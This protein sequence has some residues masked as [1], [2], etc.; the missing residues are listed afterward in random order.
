[1]AACCGSAL[2]VN[3]SA[4]YYENENMAFAYGDIIQSAGRSVQMLHTRPLILGFSSTYLSHKELQTRLT[5]VFELFGLMPG[6]MLGVSACFI[7]YMK[8]LTIAADGL[9]DV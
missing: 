6:L 2:F 1:M 3:I 9:H 4:Y 8:T 5:A 7:S